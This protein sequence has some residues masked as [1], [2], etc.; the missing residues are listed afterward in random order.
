M[1]EDS[2]LSISISNQKEPEPLSVSQI[3]GMIQTALSGQ[4]SNISVKGEISGLKIAASG[5]VYFDLKDDKA[6]INGICWRGNASRIKVKLEDGLE[7]IVKGSVSTYPAR[8]NYQLIAN[9]IEVA[10][11]GALMK[12]LEERRKKL[13][14]EGIFDSSRKQE[15]PYM[16]SCIGVV[17]SPTGAVIR[18]IIHRIA[19]R[20]GINVLLYP[21]IVQGQ[22]AAEQ[23]VEGIEFFNNLLDSNSKNLTVPE[24]LIVARGGGSIEDLWAFNEE[25]VVRAAA[26]SK[27]P[28]ISAVGHET[29][30]TLIDYASDKRAPTPT[31]AAEMAVPVKTEIQAYLM[32]LNQRSFQLINHKIGNLKRILDARASSLL[33]PKQMLIN[34]AQRLDDVSERLENSVNISLREKQYK[35]SQLTL[36]SHM[37]TSLLEQKLKE[38]KSSKALLESY[39]YKNVLNRGYSVI[40]LN[41]N[42]IAKSISDLPNGTAFEIELADGRKGAIIDYNGNEGDIKKIDTKKTSIKKTEKKIKPN[43]NQQDLF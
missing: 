23:I 10:G 41:N 8:S 19:D 33:S 30:T 5:H 25:V 11:E 28:L 1:F 29:D 3:S 4:F 27:I 36:K 43:T 21:V 12:L 14:E 40:H 9:N 35:L 16:P 31:A 37:I 2:S 42:K 13:L 22:G 18:D 20:F 7:V 26:N 32:D 15:I 34:M 17:T 24:T 38:V 39:N 6:V